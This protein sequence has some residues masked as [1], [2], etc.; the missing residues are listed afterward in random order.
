MAAPEM[1]HTSRR[2]LV[3]QRTLRRHARPNGEQLTR[4]KRM[5]TRVMSTPQRPLHNA[6]PHSWNCSNEMNR[7]A[8]RSERETETEAQEAIDYVVDFGQ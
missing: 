2:A 8:R 5:V 6:L 7:A 3:F 1:H 4:F